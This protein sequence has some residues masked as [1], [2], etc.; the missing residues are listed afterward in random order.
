MY[1]RGAADPRPVLLL[2][3]AIIVE[4]SISGPPDRAGAPPAQAGGGTP[5]GPPPAQRAAV[6]GPRLPRRGGPARALRRRRRPAHGRP[7]R[8]PDRVRARAPRP[9]ALGGGPVRSPPRP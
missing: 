7:Y 6:L 2:C 1:G 9:R 4:A 5:G 3:G 8:L